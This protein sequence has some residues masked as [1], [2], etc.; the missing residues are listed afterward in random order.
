[1][2][3]IRQLQKI[4]K[5]IKIPSSSLQ[6]QLTLE[7]VILSVIG[8]GSVAFWAGWQMEQNL[9][10]AHKQTLEYI[11]MR[12]PEQL[13]VYNEAESLE[14]V[15]EK[16]ISRVETS[17]LM[18]WVKNPQ[19]QLLGQSSSLNNS[20]VEFQAVENTQ[21]IPTKPQVVRFNG[22]DIV[23]CGTPLIVNGDMVGKLYLS[24]DITLDQQ[25]LNFSLWRLFF[26]SIVTV[27]VLVIAI[28]YT[29]STGLKPLKKMSRVA[30]TIKADDLS[31]AKLTLNQAPQEIIGLAQAFNEMLFRLSASWE[32]QRQFVG[33][34]SH[35]LRTPLT[36]VLGYL[37]SL[38]RRSDNLSTHQIQALETATAETERTIRMLEDLLDLAR[39]DSGNLHF[40]CQPLMLNTL[41]TEVAQ[42]SQKVTDR[43][44]NLIITDED[45]ITCADQDR[46]QQVLINLVDNALKYSSPPQPIDIILEKCFPNA[47]IHIRDYGIGISLAHQQRI[48]ERFYRADDGMTRSRDGTG[49]G[50]ALAKGMIEGM[51]GTIKVRSKPQEGSVFTISL[52]LWG[53]SHD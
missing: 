41:V 19:G 4:I 7:L 1:M 37:Q 28:S 48:F 6:F 32:Q 14:T 3:L 45:V 24:Q 43:T 35:E 49:L 15:I 52:P 10:A 38:L 29:I 36:I 50:L 9:V 51:E 16:A 53:D 2:K 40:H 31:G 42:M 20:L 33:N 13:E 46:L 23:L 12:F 18:V 5:K 26:I 25:K 8:L 30:S 39:A 47:L 21:Q 44:I 17:N 22:R 27:T 11:A 34:V